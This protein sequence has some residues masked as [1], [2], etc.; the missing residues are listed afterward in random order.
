MLDTYVCMF[1]QS[2]IA[3]GFCCCFSVSY[4]GRNVHLSLQVIMESSPNAVDLV[5]KYCK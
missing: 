3:T 2:L 1:I 4:V 5:N